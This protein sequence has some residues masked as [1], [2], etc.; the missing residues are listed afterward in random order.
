MMATASEPDSGP[1]TLTATF[2]GN[3]AFAITD[4]ATTLYTDFPYESGAFGYMQYDFAAVPKDERSLCLITHAHRDH[5]APEL[6][7]KVGCRVVVSGNGAAAL[8]AGISMAP[9]PHISWGAIE[10]DSVET[11]HGDVDHHS[12]LVAWGGVRLYFTGDT[13]S[14]E[15]LLAERSLDAAFVSPRLL[16]AVA[17]SGKRIDARR[18]I[19]YHHRA[20]E[21]VPEVLDRVVPRQGDKI[22]IAARTPSLSVEVPI[23]ELLAR[24]Q[25][26]MRRLS[27]GI[28]LIAAK[29]FDF[30]GDQLYLPAFQQDPTFFYFTGLAVAPGAVLALDAPRERAI[31][32]APAR[33]PRYDAML[34]WVRIPA[35]AESAARF[36]ATEVLDR[37]ELGPYLARRQEET[38]GL[39]LY[40]P[41]IAE[42]PPGFP[43][44]AALDDPAAAW[45]HALAEL[46]PAGRVRNADSAVGEMRAI[47]SDAEIA[48]LRRVGASSA[49]A[50]KAGLAAL[51]PG[52]PQREAEAAVV[53]ACIAAGAEGHSFWPWVM[54][55]ENGAFPKPFESLVDYRHL[56]RRMAA[57]EV[58]RVD[59]G[60]DVDHYKGDVGRTAPVSGR[61]DAGQRETW[62]LLLAA[63]RAGL[64]RLH[65]GVRRDDVFAASLAEVRKRQPSLKTP[66]GRRAAEVLLGADGL[67]WWGIHG[68]GLEGAEG[69]PETLRA[70]MVVAFEPIL[71]VEGKG[72][73]LEDMILVTRDGHEVLTKGL[74]YSAEELERAVRGTNSPKH[75]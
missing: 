12:Y 46:W 59:V 58:A 62:E 28:L 1:T 2:I 26:A 32:F 39:I 23:D 50:L 10:I 38:P 6:V 3:E 19:V 33:L 13:D 73:Y 18:V 43:L 52:K 25:E 8:P 71:V 74:P 49:A 15:A 4:G 67:R 64:S 35:G 30:A 36:A 24:R 34:S 47:K 31:L 14:A 54:A 72:F 7:A 37:K 44:D 11:P 42:G 48:T 75:P 20:D 40:A 55:G 29:P 45:N 22:R 16:K 63:Y 41:G 57:G 68:V 27:D 51:A 66:L 21:S 5:F 61:F 9:A 69:A 65:D 70:G 56:N 53:S 60:C 17:E